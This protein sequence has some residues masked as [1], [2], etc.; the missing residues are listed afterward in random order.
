MDV[1]G[2]ELTF[3]QHLERENARVAAMARSMAALSLDEQYIM[4]HVLHAFVAAKQASEDL[5]LE[6]E[7]SA[8]ASQGGAWSPLPLPLS[9]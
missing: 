4:G 5:Q 2:Y 8:E 7:F 9:A 3:E 6:F 1:L